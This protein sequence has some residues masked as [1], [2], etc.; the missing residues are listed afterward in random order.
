MT[1]ERVYLTDPF[2]WEFTANVVEKKELPEG[3][4]VVL[5]DRTCFY[6]TGGGQ[7]HDKGTLGGATVLDIENDEYGNIV[8]IVDRPIEGTVV[9]G[10]VDGSRRFAFMQHHSAQ[11]LVSA[12]L[13]QLPGLETVSS[14]ISIDSPTTIDVPGTSVAEADLLRVED[15]ANEMIWQDRPIRSYM[16]TNEQVRSLPFRRPPKV[17]GEIRVVEI[18]K[19][20]YSACGGTHCTRTGMIGVC[21][22]LRAERRGDKTRVHLVAGRRA[23]E[24]FQSEHAIVTLTARKLDTGPEGIAAALERHSEALRAAQDE[25]EKLREEKMQWEAKAIAAKAEVV[26]GIRLVTLGLRDRTPQAIRALA[27]QLQHEPGV[28]ALIAAYDGARL[29]LTVTCAED[30][31]IRANEL[32][33]KQLAEI[34]GRGGGDARL[35]QGGGGAS[36]EQF[37]GLFAKTRELIKG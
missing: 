3:R 23:L 18:E 26:D 24:T 25:L 33:R 20:D 16:I 8:H 9:K 7:E 34:G 31:G 1:T 36:E 30:T 17:S 29:T 12:V 4:Q 2:C 22:I 11:H 6:P 21:K 27:S 14:H 37:R 28:V 35:A 10:A 15:T 32:I 5:L 19:Y 13:D